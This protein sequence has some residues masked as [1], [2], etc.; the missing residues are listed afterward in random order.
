MRQISDDSHL[1]KHLKES[2][3]SGSKYSNA[4]IKYLNMLINIWLCNNYQH[5][6]ACRYCLKQNCKW[7]P[8]DNVSSFPLPTRNLIQLVSMEYSL[9]CAAIKVQKFV[10]ILNTCKWPVR[11]SGE[12]PGGYW[13]LHTSKPVGGTESCRIS[14]RIS[15]LGS[16]IY[17]EK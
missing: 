9:I 5:T 8:S 11:R 14:E 2:N 16:S 1:G 17:P 6:K 10:C 13:V 15:S 4:S 3:R 12:I 7:C